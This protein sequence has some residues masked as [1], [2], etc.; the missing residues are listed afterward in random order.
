[1]DEKHESDQSGVGEDEEQRVLLQFQC[2]SRNRRHARGDALL[3]SLDERVDE[4]DSSPDGPNLESCD[5]RIG[6]ALLRLAC[7]GK[8]E[9]DW[10]P[11]RRGEML[12]I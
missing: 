2:A 12:T 4:V 9:S 3:Q 7:F 5:H 1:M 6:G 10:S 11:K 8:E